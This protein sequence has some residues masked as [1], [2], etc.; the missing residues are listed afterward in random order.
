VICLRGQELDVCVCSLCYKMN[1]WMRKVKMK[2]L[3]SDAKRGKLRVIALFCKCLD[4]RGNRNSE[5]GC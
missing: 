1:A 2:Y 3:E 4:W 5:V